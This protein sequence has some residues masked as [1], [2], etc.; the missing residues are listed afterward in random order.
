MK[1][2][3]MIQAGLWLLFSF[4]LVGSQMKLEPEEILLN[5]IREM[6][7]QPEIAVLHHGSRVEQGLSS[8]QLDSFVVQLMNSLQLKNKKKETNRDGIKYIATGK[9]GRNINIDLH[10]INDEPT[11]T[12]M[13]PYISIQLKSR[14]QTDSEWLRARNI[15]VHAL[16]SNGLIP[17]L[18]IS[19][20][21]SMKN[22][23]SRLEQPIVQ[24]LKKL[25]ATEIES[26]RTSH[27]VS[28]SAYSPQLPDR[29]KTGGGWMNVQVASRWSHD[30]QRLIFTIGTPIIT[31]EY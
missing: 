11:S 28:I 27:T 29:L 8:K 31:I 13:K 2:F 16:Q 26:M 22:M 17:K 5:T 20:Q 21:G 14:G 3:S 4:C 30:N 10:V 1:Y 15:I 12:W 19:F 9:I 25:H 18:H 24:A 23:S 7:V 6:G